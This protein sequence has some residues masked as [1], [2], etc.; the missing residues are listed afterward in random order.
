M[1][2]YKTFFKV[3]KQYK[4]SLIMYSAIVAFMLIVLVNAES[5]GSSELVVADAKYNLLVVDN[6]QSDISK[7]FVSYL[8]KKH[9]LKKGDFSD[10]QIKDMLYYE[11]ISEYIVIPKGFGED[12]KNAENPA[13]LLE[14]TY[15]E[16]LP[17][18]I[19]INMQINQYLNAV[20]GYMAQGVELKDAST[21]TAE[22]L[23]TSKFVEMQ[24]TEVIESEK[25][26]TSFM[27]L[28]FGILTIIFSGV[29]PVI[30][31]FNETEKKN[32]TL[33][34][35][36]KMTSRNVSLIMGVAT[37]ALVVTSI[38]VAMASMPNNGSYIGTKP[39][40]LSVLNTIIYTLTVTMLLSMITSL[41]LGLV[42]K[43]SAS[44]T[45]FFTVIIGLSFAFLGGTFVP[46]EI[47]GDKVAAIGRF[48]PNYWYSTALTKIWNE[49]AGLSDVIG[50]FGLELL[51]GVA[52]L[53]IGLGFTRFFGEKESA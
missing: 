39:W 34:S 12:F 42:T 17:R 28:P 40:A 53:S 29:L 23:D 30:I 36:H 4:L 44:T 11:A 22:A 25:I 41:P 18:G 35:S 46:L 14:A 13:T 43:G 50:S 49:G 45:S 7:E 9:T 24:K 6:D 27:F 26:H 5:S 31:S 52:C 21:K 20:R 48:T 8:G 33:I 16:A 2:V 1:L 37:I 38:L 47:L 3:M 19:F 15:D 10:D 32:R 51:F